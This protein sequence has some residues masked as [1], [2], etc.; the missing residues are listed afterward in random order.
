MPKS[1]PN[2]NKPRFEPYRGGKEEKEVV[3]ARTEQY[4]DSKEADIRAAAK[5]AWEKV[6]ATPMTIVDISIL[7]DETCKIIANYLDSKSADLLSQALP[8][9]FYPIEFKMKV[10]QCKDPRWVNTITYCRTTHPSAY[11]NGL[12][13]WSNV[14]TLRFEHAFCCAL[15]WLEH[16]PSIKYVEVGSTTNMNDE[17]YQHILGLPKLERLVLVNNKWT[18][19]KCKFRNM[20][21]SSSVQELALVSLDE[22]MK[23]VGRIFPNLKKAIINNN[24]GWSIAGFPNVTSL[25]LENIGNQQDL[26]EWINNNPNL[27]HFELRACEITD[28]NIN[29][30][31]SN[32]DTL[33]S[34]KFHGVT[35]SG[36]FCFPQ[37]HELTRIRSIPLLKGETKSMVSLQTVTLGSMYDLDHISRFKSLKHLV[38]M[39][40]KIDLGWLSYILPPYVETVT[41]DHVTIVNHIKKIH[42]FP[43]LKKV[44]STNHSD[45]SNPSFAGLEVIII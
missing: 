39:N 32:C 9:L 20:P 15:E 4:C 38:L 11:P 44:Y 30:A 40:T 28:P 8:N 25:N 27:T 5:A 31:L 18:R 43:S 29:V 33:R 45:K 10:K 3:A 42:K 13:E 7:S 35:Y 12:C 1:S 19:R 22:E 36:S 14:R 37:I 34:I 23:E 16:V 21:V 41:F 26:A 17:A 6:T 2:R 24:N